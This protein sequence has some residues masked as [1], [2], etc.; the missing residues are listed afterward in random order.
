MQQTATRN[1][2]TTGLAKRERINRVETRPIPDRI[3]GD[4]A[5]FNGDS[6]DFRHAG[7]STLFTVAPS[8]VSIDSRREDSEPC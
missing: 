4:L 2:K 3:Q 5:H 8:E 1:D 7:P 6:Q